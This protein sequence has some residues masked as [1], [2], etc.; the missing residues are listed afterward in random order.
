MYRFELPDIGEG[1]VEAEVLA[2]HVQEG[3]WIDEDQR[4]V[5][6]LTDKAEI[7]VPSPRAGRVHR[8]AHPV[9]AIVPVGEV[10]IEIDDEAE[11]GES[12]PP[13]P[14]AS[15][16]AGPSARQAPAPES[17]PAPAEVPEPAAPLRPA[18]PAPPVRA[19][20]GAAHPPVQPPRPSAHPRDGSAA[21]G[22]A[23]DAVPAVRELA[24][25]LGVEL[26]RIEGSGPGGRIMRRDVE[27]GASGASEAPDERAPAA[28]AQAADQA[29]RPRATRTPSE[30]PPDWERV[31][32]RGVRRAIATHMREARQRA[33][34][35][36]Y[37]DEID[38]SE[39]STRLEQWRVSLS[40]L[41]FIAHGTVRALPEFREL[42]ASIDDERE[43]IVYKG[44]VHLGVATAAPQGLVV[45]V[46]HDAAALSVEA[47]AERIRALAER[48]RAGKLEPTELRGSTFTITSLG[49]LGGV[50][51]TP[52]V[53]HP[54]V[55]IL[56]VNAIRELPRYVA[57]ELRARRVMNLSLSVDHRIA[58][59]VVAARFIERLR[60]MLETVDFPGVFPEGARA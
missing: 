27:R 56:G 2:W 47:L 20:G 13:A 22:G 15:R 25:R 21:E 16:E 29:P 48:A 50:V 45:P 39:L 52:I 10:L 40:P 3:D 17:E 9:G 41:A 8:L 11:L 46:V 30:D 26:G 14:G 49:K 34:H 43:E 44:T 1:V 36:T 6:L 24:K 58:D 37:V 59:G 57:G 18:R 5:E 28:P 42:H 53:N 19:A 33:A 4:M 35:F 23:V 51:S 32:L 60:E 12:K 38:M 31:P 54:E 55:A 7:E